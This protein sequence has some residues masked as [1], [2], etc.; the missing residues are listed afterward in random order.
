MTRQSIVVVSAGLGQ[1]SSTR[2]LAERMAAA[3]SDALLEQGQETEVRFVD[4]RDHAH[5][6]ADTLLTGFATGDLREAL[7]ALYAADGVIAVTPVFQA[8]FSGLFKT[9]FDVVEDGALKGMPV[10]LAA[11]AGTARHS[12]VLEHALRPMFAYLKASSVPTAVFAASEDW[13][14]TTADQGLAGRIEVAAEELAAMVAGTAARA[15]TDPF[16]DPV[17]FE[18]LLSGG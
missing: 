9:F 13:G 3:S 4:L 1:P 12:L 8:S 10:L 18:R 16:A 17:P 2:L 7:D 14:G 11:T 5:A 15:V 6:L